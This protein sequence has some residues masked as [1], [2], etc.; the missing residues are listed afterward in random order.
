MKVCVV[1]ALIL[2]LSASVVHAQTVRL[3]GTVLD[4]SGAVIPGADVRV[5]QG[6]RVIGEGK[7]DAT[8]NFSFDVHA[9]EYRVEV[10]APEFKTHV[11]NVRVAANMRPFSIALAVAAVN[12]AVDVAPTDDK[13]ALDADANLTSTT[14]SGDRVR[15]LP[16]DEDALMAQLQAL[17]AGGGA[18]GSTATFVVD[19]FSNGRKYRRPAHSDHHET[20]NRSMEREHQSQLQQETKSIACVRCIRMPEISIS[21]NPPRSCSRKTWDC[22]FIRRTTSLSMA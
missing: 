4:P 9:G 13:V 22:G 11:Q 19:G 3:R 10:S 14:I 12:A 21:S 7:S 15:D 6:N 2:L 17:A 5:S 18:A 20:G 16:E 1:V 8:G